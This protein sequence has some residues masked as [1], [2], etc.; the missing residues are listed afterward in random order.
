MGFSKKMVAKAIQAH[1]KST[2]SFTK[3][4]IFPLNGSFIRFATLL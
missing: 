4:H 1:G 3:E 2:I